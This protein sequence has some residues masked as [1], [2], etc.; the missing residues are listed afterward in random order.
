MSMWK[1]AVFGVVAGGVVE[2]SY[3][4]EQCHMPGTAFTILCVHTYTQIDS[5]LSLFLSLPPSLN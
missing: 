1:E 5:Y 3:N 4:S 2:L